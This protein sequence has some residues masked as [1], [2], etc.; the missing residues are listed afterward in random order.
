MRR[1]VLLALL[2][3]PAVAH[4]R[5]LTS[6]AGVVEAIAGDPSQLFWSVAGGVSALDNRSIAFAPAPCTGT[7][8]Y[9]FARTISALPVGTSGRFAVLPSFA[10]AA[11]VVVAQAVCTVCAPGPRPAYTTLWANVPIT[12]TGTMRFVSLD[13]PLDVRTFGIAGSGVA[14]A[15]NAYFPGDPGPWNF[16]VVHYDF[17]YTV[18]PEPSSLA[19]L[20]FGVVG[21]AIARRRWRRSASSPS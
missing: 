7:C 9:D 5:Q 10:F 2:C 15:E 18:V 20:G 13:D 4:A 3:I 1:L 19:L 11:P 14:R 8:S 12:V 21:V 17:T 16:S 6:G